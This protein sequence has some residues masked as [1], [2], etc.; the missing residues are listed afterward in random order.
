MAHREVQAFKHIQ[1]MR[2][3]AKMSNW[4]TCQICLKEVDSVN[5]ED[6]NRRS[7][8][9]RAKCHGAEDV[10]TVRFDWD[11]Q[12]TDLGIPLHAAFFPVDLDTRFEEKVIKT[13]VG[14]DLVKPSAEDKGNTE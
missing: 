11:W 2:K 1:E 13:T 4:P 12:D 7:V 10:V 6:A 14:V 9:V 8:T 5:M 3:R